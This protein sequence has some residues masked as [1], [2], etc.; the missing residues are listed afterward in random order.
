MK[1]L[2]IVIRRDLDPGL[3]AAQA[4]HALQAMNDQHPG[5]TRA[6]EGNIVLLSV[7]GM[8][9][10]SE[11][12]CRLQRSKIPVATFSEPDIGGEPTSM[13][14]HGMAW[15]QLSCLPLALRRPHAVAA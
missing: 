2:F 3:Q 11:L 4:C 9:E 1:K 5:V 13:A 8:K 12:Q 7:S 6:W 15:K 10:L 14:V